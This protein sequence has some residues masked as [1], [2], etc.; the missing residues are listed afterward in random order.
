MKEKFL[1]YVALLTLFSTIVEPKRTI[2]KHG[3]QSKRNAIIH[4]PIKPNLISRHKKH[5]IFTLAAPP[6]ISSLL[7]SASHVALMPNG[8]P[9]AAG[10]YIHHLMH[11]HPLNIPVYHGYSPKGVYPVHLPQHYGPLGPFG[12]HVFYRH[13]LWRRGDRLGLGYGA[14]YPYAHGFV[15][16]PWYTSL[17]HGLGYGY[18]HQ[19]RH[20]LWRGLHVGHVP[21]NYVF[22]RAYRHGSGYGYGHG[23][24]GYGHFTGNWFHPLR[25]WYPYSFDHSVDLRGDSGPD[26]MF[27][28]KSSIPAS[29]GSWLG[30]KT[31]PRRLLKTRHKSTLTKRVRAHFPVRPSY[32]RFPLRRN[33]IPVAF[34]IQRLKISLPLLKRMLKR[35]KIY[36]KIIKSQ[37]NK[38]TGYVRRSE[39]AND[40][41]KTK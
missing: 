7:P 8:V 12:H 13:G 6:S 17:R 19:F 11:H 33:V 28:E 29:K 18:H 30:S 35:S 36:K 27:V 26:I 24:P 22:R 14:P 20:G 10:K 34:R 31:N 37:I 2:E 40:S 1:K 25:G 9:T 16:S 4:K 38:A 23:Y 32:R 15:R 5:D 39:Q 41:K 3:H 21:G